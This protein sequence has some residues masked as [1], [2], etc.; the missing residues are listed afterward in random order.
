MS[1]FFKK[2]NLNSWISFLIMGGTPL[3]MVLVF[4]FLGYDNS[5]FYVVFTKLL[6]FFSI[7]YFFMRKK[8]I[9]RKSILMKLF[10]VFWVLWFVRVFYDS[11]FNITSQL[12]L[13]TSNYYLF[14]FFFAILPFFY[15][16]LSKDYKSIQGVLNG[17]LVS[18][19]VFS[20][21]VLLLFYTVLSDAVDGSGNKINLIVE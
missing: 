11:Y 9:L 8:N 2:I 15:G 1:S 14:S 7:L 18:I 20:I 6:L 3:I 12:M 13:E 17:V 5:Y 4:Y 19:V 21:T 10:I 16:N